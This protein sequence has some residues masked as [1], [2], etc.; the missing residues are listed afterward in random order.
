[1][2]TKMGLGM[3]KPQL[4]SINVNKSFTGKSQKISNHN[5]VAL[6][7]S[8]LIMQENALRTKNT[9]G[10]GSGTANLEKIM[11]PLGLH[12]SSVK[13]MHLNPGNKVE[14]NLNTFNNTVNDGLPN[15]Y[16]FFLMLN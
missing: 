1:M 13:K 12:N 9:G 10:S 8:N 2:I 3:N 4:S 11:G 15:T 14:N 7:K 6:N 16:N 5:D